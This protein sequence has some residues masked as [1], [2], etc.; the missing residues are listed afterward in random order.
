MEQFKSTLYRQTMFAEFERDMH[1]AYQNGETLT[2]EY[3]SNHYYELVKKYH[4][5]SVTVD[6][7][8]ALE[9][10]RIP[11]FYTPFYVYQYATSFAASFA[12]YEN[13]S[14][15]KPNAFEK[16]VGLLKA[17]GSKYPIEE[18]LEAGIDFTKKETFEAVTNRMDELVNELEKLLKE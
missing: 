7:A 16:Y 5:P 3:L 14:K 4:G 8:I 13:I 18:A 2:A 12:I 15:N 9:W 10:S 6:E 17:G 11:H 1:L